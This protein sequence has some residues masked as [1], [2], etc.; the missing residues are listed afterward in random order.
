MD[1]LDAEKKKLEEA[2]IKLAGGAPYRAAAAAVAQTLGV[3][4][5]RTQ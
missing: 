2:Y 3:E 5:T 1:E 4:E